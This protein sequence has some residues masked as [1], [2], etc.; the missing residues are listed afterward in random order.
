MKGQTVQSDRHG[1]CQLPLT[2]PI[3]SLSRFSYD[4][5]VL[6]LEDTRLNDLAHWPIAKSKPEPQRENCTFLLWFFLL[7]FFIAPSSFILSMI[8]WADNQ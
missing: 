5:S 6:L 7:T 4:F 8:L 3:R 1:S 2:V